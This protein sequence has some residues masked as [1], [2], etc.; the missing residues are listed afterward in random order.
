MKEPDLESQEARDAAKVGGFDRPYVVIN[1]YHDEVTAKP[2]DMGKTMWIRKG[3]SPLVANSDGQGYMMSGFLSESEMLCA[4]GDEQVRDAAG[5]LVDDKE[6]EPVLGGTV[7]TDD[8]TVVDSTSLYWETGAKG[9]GYFCCDNLVQQIE[10]QLLPVFHARYPRDR[11]R[12]LV[13]FDNATLHTAY[14]P[15]AL[16]ASK[17][18]MTDN[19]KTTPKMRTTT[20]TDVDGAVHHQDMQFS[21]GKTKGM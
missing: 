4:P 8:G 19:T 10:S 2:A 16:V 18:S 21:N 20:W 14:A 12:A 13:H 6:G 5:R 17:V 1:V 9:D 3:D 11:Y 7:V 15:D